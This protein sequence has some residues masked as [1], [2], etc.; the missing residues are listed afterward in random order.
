MTVFF[1]QAGD[2]AFAED[3]ENRPIDTD[4]RRNRPNSDSVKFSF[5]FKSTNFQRIGETVLPRA[6][7]KFGQPDPRVTVAQNNRVG[8][9]GATAGMLCRVTWAL[10]VMPEK[11]S[12]R[13]EL[14]QAGWDDAFLSHLLAAF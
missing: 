13:G 1:G 3:F 5:E 11:G 9:K 8:V 14:K 7:R 10:N 4:S 6:R 2:A 12:P